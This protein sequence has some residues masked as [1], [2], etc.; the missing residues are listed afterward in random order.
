MTFEKD[1]RES[2]TLDE[3]AMLNEIKEK[4]ISKKLAMDVLE[5]VRDNYWDQYVY[6]SPANLNRL[7]DRHG[8]LP[9]G[10][11]TADRQSVTLGTF[12]GAA[13]GL[14]VYTDDVELVRGEKTIGDTRKIKT[15][16]DVYKMAGIKVV[17]DINKPT[18]SRWAA[19]PSRTFRP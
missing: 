5:L 15:N 7:K 4:N 16:A 19:S 6:L 17:S 3:L 1:L 12:I 13:T 8:K 10:M 9:R 14:D 11:P 18:K 2:V